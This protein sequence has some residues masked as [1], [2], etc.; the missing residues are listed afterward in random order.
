MFNHDD[1]S[2]KKNNNKVQNLTNGNDPLNISI[3]LLLASNILDD[4]NE[5]RTV[6]YTGTEGQGG[7]KT[8]RYFSL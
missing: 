5:R 1:I 6:I 8:N 3:E 4:R 7:E 2:L